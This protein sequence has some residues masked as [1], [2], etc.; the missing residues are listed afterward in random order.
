LKAAG[1]YFVEVMV[2]DVMKLRYPIPVIHSPPAE[3]N[4]PPE[5]K[6]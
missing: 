4:P 6:G 1:T 2:D 3:K 5:A